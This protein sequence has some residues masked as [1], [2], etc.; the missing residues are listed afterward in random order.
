MASWLRMLPALDQSSFH[1][2]CL[3]WLTTACNCRGFNAF[4]WPPQAL[5]LM[6]TDKESFKRLGTMESQGLLE[7][8]NKNKKVNDV[9]G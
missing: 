2:R 7:G 3:R 1:S 6:C 9:S 4:Y 8:F 5:V